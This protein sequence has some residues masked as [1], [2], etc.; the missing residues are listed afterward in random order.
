MSWKKISQT[1]LIRTKSLFLSNVVY[2]FVYIPVCEH[3]SFPKIIHPP[4][5]CGTSRSWLNSII[6]TQST[7]KC[8]VLHADCRNVHQSCCQRIYCSF[9]CHLNAQIY[10]A[11][12]R[13]WGP[14]P[15]HS[16]AAIP[17]CLSMRM[18]FLEAENVSV[19]AILTRHVTI[20]HVWDAVDW[21]CVPVT[22]PLQF[23]KS[24]PTFHRP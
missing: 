3:F 18:Q 4:D 6:I 12:M 20:E 9:F 14:L 1:F 24:G 2:K 5:R 21:Q 23:L 22:A 19:L 8:E 13:S 16:S 15:Y 10:C 17:S 7:Q 11:V